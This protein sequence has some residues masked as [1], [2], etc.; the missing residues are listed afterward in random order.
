VRTLFLTSG[1]F[2]AIAAEALEIFRP[3]NA[4]LTGGDIISSKAVHSVL[5]GIDGITVINIYGPTEN[6]T[7]TCCHRMTKGN[8]PGATVPIG[9]PIANTTVY[10][11]DADLRPVLPGE[12]G[13]LCTG[14]DGVAIGYLNLPDLTRERFVVDP[15][16]SEPGA[17]MYRTGDLARLLSDGNIEFLGRIDRQVK[18]R[19]FRIELDE[20]EVALSQH[21]SI[22]QAAITTHDFGP[23]DRRIIAYYTSAESRTSLDQ[24]LRTF[25]RAKL[26]AYMLPHH[27]IR[28]DALPLT[29]N[30]KVDRK[31]LPDPSDFIIRKEATAPLS[32]TERQVAALMAE[33]LHCGAVDPDD[34]FF[35][36]GGHSL[37]AFMLLAR[38]TSRFGEAVSIRAFFSAPTVRMLA[39]A[40][41]QRRTIGT[42]SVEPPLAPSVYTVGN[43]PQ[44]FPQQRLWFLDRFAPEAMVYVLPFAFRLHGH[45]DPDPLQRALN[46]LVERHEALRTTFDLADGQPAQRINV[47]WEVPFPVVDLSN[48]SGREDELNIF[49]RAEIRKGFDLARGPLLRAFLIRMAE[50]EYIFFF[51]VHH[52]VF[53]GW[54]LDVF[55]REL[56]ECYEAYRNG[57][58][59]SLPS[60]E[61]QYRD[62]TLWQINR[63]DDAR[64]A[65]HLAYW[66][67]ALGGELPILDLPTDRIRPAALTYDG[68]LLQLD[69]T[70]ELTQKLSALALANKG[71]LFMA[72]AAVLAVLLFRYSGQRDILLGC[73]V[74]DRGRQEFEGTIGFFVNTLP[75]RF[76]FDGNP[77][78][79]DFFILTR[80]TLLSALEHQDAPFERIVEA[81]G[82]PRHPDR[83]PMVQAFFAYEDLSDQPATL[84][85][86]DFRQIHVDSGLART[87]L[88]V[89][90][91]RRDGKFEIVAEYN[92]NLFDQE[93]M[94]RF[95]AHF[96]NLLEDIV[97]RPNTGIEEFNLLSDAEKRQLLVDWNHTASPYPRTATVYELFQKEA[98]AAP[99]SVALIHDNGQVTYDEL[100]KTANRLAH[101]LLDHG[102]RP[103][104]RVGILAD[105][106]S[107]FVIAVLAVL[108]TGGAYVPLDPSYP[109]ERLEFMLRDA[110]ASVILTEE[111]LRR[112]SPPGLAEVLSLDDLTSSGLEVYPDTAPI[113]KCGPESPAYVMYTS[114]STGVP[115]GIEVTHRG[116]VRLVKNTNY[117]SLD[118]DTVLLQNS[119]VAFDASTFEIWGALLN[120]GR[121]V[122]AP[123]GLLSAEELGRIIRK[124][125]VTTLWLTTGFFHAI[126]EED[127]NIFAPLRE[128]LTGGDVVSMAAVNWVLHTLPALKIINGYGP[129]E[130]TT[131][132]C[133]HPVGAIPREICGRMPIGR[134][135]ANTRVYILDSRL[136]PVPVGVVGELYAAGDGVA[137]GYC[138]RPDLTAKVF[139][140]DP[141]VDDENARIYKTGDLARYLADG[142]IDF[143]G[144]ADTQVKIRGYRIE[145]GEIEQILLQ[146]GTV[147]Q[148]AVICLE[149]E[150]K[151]KQLVAYIVPTQGCNQNPAGIKAFLHERLPAYMIPRH[152]IW[153]DD[154]PLNANGKLDRKAL[155][156]PDPL[157]TID[158]DVYV[159]PQTETEM[160]L[161]VIWQEILQLNRVSMEDNFFK[162]GGHSL[163]AVRLFVRI[164][165]LTKFDLPLSTLFKVPTIRGLAKIIDMNF[166]ATSI[167]N[168][169]LEPQTEK[170]RSLVTIQQ[171]GDQPPLFL[172]HAAGGNV[173]N[174]RILL[175][176]LGSAQPVY[177]LQAR[178]LDGVQDPFSSIEEMARVYLAEIRFVQDSGPYYLGG[179]SFGGLVAFEIAQQL[180]KRGERVSF[181]A[182]LDTPGPGKRG[183][184]SLFSFERGLSGV[185][186]AFA[187]TSLPLYLYKKIC[188]SIRVRLHNT[189]RLT[190]Y[191]FCRLTNSPLPLVL[192]AWYLTRSHIRI[193]K[194]YIVH[195]YHNSSIALFRGPVTHEFPYNDPELGWKD[196]ARGGL[197]IIIINALHREFLESPEL[198]AQFARELRT[199]QNH[200][201]VDDITFN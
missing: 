75:I 67:E 29:P 106:S 151:D 138:N 199:A 41:E 13:E 99:L 135:I 2:H 46:T 104:M 184:R 44:S 8:P 200:S 86:S 137:Q 111:R 89:W 114:G 122:L 108:K 107:L 76:T 103:G 125:G 191:V 144:R 82:P 50:K 113:V 167:N 119:S 116:I 47:P 197:K 20:I 58:E 169:A 81:V 65:G 26:P 178:G 25:L 152:M 181:L 128:L 100:E 139:L 16:S 42:L 156:A 187:Y 79:V 164:Q 117:V 166:S 158:E 90:A 124:W 4:L 149:D 39:A 38:L 30:G 85:G 57:R 74:S 78:F 35:A 27:F 163:L 10:I 17:R 66:R 182:M 105:R 141:F 142:V 153:L 14:G 21:E 68:A 157:A 126:A 7:F 194:R 189:M 174:Y 62:F 190:R 80:E 63:T 133:C 91:F 129:T 19:G 12:A 160:H 64:L 37:L 31:A 11:L 22:Q 96:R 34:D 102:I 3:L 179:E 188:N 84:D 33:V 9:R 173:L 154:L 43:L 136:Q 93:T 97:A 54:S 95:L 146:Y 165:N 15:F 73:P 101:L 61:V 140:A 175:G 77:S 123:P 195:P 1:L 51:L 145:L 6:T 109:R 201:L 48:N 52:I 94:C 115:K 148:A 177:G 130:N 28:L 55:L 155:P 193:M 186:Y 192:R 72:L 134:P 83:T 112:F 24:E 198:H 40:I 131:F 168:N 118:R 32:E 162:I 53:D 98:I 196:I 36:L 132:T 147:R 176:A 185:R 92:T 45:V 180:A 120:G 150:A 59:P 127:P 143:L 60:L 172:I 161:A 70:P 183:Y 110:A 5:E 18:V 23:E 171:T 170:W 87:D 159:P 121:L 56:K 88:T 71:S 69:I 49:M